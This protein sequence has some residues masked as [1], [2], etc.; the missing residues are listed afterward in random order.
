MDVGRAGR[1]VRGTCAPA[2]P[3]ACQTRVAVFGVERVVA[4]HAGVEVFVEDKAAGEAGNGMVHAY[5]CESNL[6]DRRCGRTGDSERDSRAFEGGSFSHTAHKRQYP[7]SLSHHPQP[8]R[9]LSD[10]L[11]DHVPRN[12]NLRPRHVLH[13]LVFEMRLERIALACHQPIPETAYVFRVLLKAASY[14]TRHE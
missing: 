8:T 11:P 4:F 14:N 9:L 5:F 12:L 3:R 7:L 10:S 1:G 2:L 13:L 6:D